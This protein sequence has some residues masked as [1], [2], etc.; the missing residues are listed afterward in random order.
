MT[1]VLLAWVPTRTTFWSGI[2]GGCVTHWNID[3]TPSSSLS[4]RTHVRLDEDVWLPGNPSDRP[5]EAPPR[6][7]TWQDGI[8]IKESADVFVVPA[9]GLRGR[10]ITLKIGST[11]IED[12]LAPNPTSWTEP[13]FR[14]DCVSI[15][16]KRDAESLQLAPFQKRAELFEAKASLG[17]DIDGIQ[18][19]VGTLG[20]TVGAFVRF[21]EGDPIL[22]E[23]LCDAVYVDTNRGELELIWRGIYF[24]NTWS[25]DV[26]H[27]LIGILPP[28]LEEDAQIERLEEGLPLAAFSYAATSDDIEKQVA[29]PRL[30]EEDLA[31]ARLSTWENGPGACILTQDE[32]SQI[33]AELASRPRGEVLDAHGFDEIGWSREEWAQSERIANESASLPDDLGD[34]DKNADIQVKPVRPPF[35]PRKIEISEYARLSAHLELRDPARVLSESKLSVNEFLIIEET[36]ATLIDGDEALAAAFDTHIAAYRAEAR[37]AHKADLERI[38][39]DDQDEPSSDT[40]ESK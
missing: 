6:V 22:V 4:L 10:T 2:S 25:A 26:E 36:M 12:A 7:P 30:R 1:R 3:G 5:L 34:D 37:T 24:D 8:P 35:T 33:S 15:K 32:F 23:M 38:G 21:K 14:R 16:V 9:P 13:G 39:M 20:F 17:W 28:D 18:G 27:I 29:P 11:R 40:A 19:P 31:M